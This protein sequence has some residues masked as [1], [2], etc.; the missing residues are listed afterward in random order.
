MHLQDRCAIGADLARLRSQLKLSSSDFNYLLG[1]THLRYIE[2]TRQ[3]PKD[4][5]DDPALALLVWALFNFPQHS[6]IKP[7]PR[8]AQAAFE[9][10]RQVAKQLHHAPS[11]ARLA[12]GGRAKRNISLGTKRAFGFMLGTDISGGNRWLSGHANIGAVI[13]RLLYILL[14][15]CAK[16]GPEGLRRWY[17]RVLVEAH[18]RGIDDLWLNKTWYPA[19]EPTTPIQEGGSVA[20]RRMRIGDLMTILERYQLRKTD[21]PYLIGQVSQKIAQLRTDGPDAIILNPSLA[22]LFWAL[23]EYPEYSY[24]IDR[25]PIHAIF[26]SYRAAATPLADL[27]KQHYGITADNKRIDKVYRL[28]TVQALALMAGSRRALGAL[29]LNETSSPRP[30]AYYLLLVL[31]NLCDK[32]GAAGLKR[33]FDRVVFE[34]QQRGIENLWEHRHWQSD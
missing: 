6:Y 16:E 32:E 12:R 18:W 22:L 34:S 8:D 26:D 11:P 27:P 14:E 30:H 17:Q 19:Q 10:Y 13:Q 7:L 28:D 20:S 4:V 9:Q 31:K 5:L 23:L 25:H 3:R 29:W 1:L 33:W 24:C 21:S 15:V 2:L